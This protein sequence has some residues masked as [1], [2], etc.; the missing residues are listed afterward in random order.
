MRFGCWKDDGCGGEAGERE[1]L[2]RSLRPE[3]VWTRKSD[4]VWDAVEK[5]V[6]CSLARPLH[7]EGDGI[8]TMASERVLRILVGGKSRKGSER[9]RELGR[10]S[11]GSNRD[12]LGR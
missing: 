11:E 3:E 4:E 5:V 12:L 6:D 7:D 10:E 2:R 1:V 8:L 9:C